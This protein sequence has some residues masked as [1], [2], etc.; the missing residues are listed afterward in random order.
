MKTWGCL[1]KQ[2]IILDFKLAQF[3]YANIK[4][5]LPTKD[6]RLC[7]WGLSKKKLGQILTIFLAHT[8]KEMAYFTQYECVA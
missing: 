3:V 1:K 8:G 7:Y 6:R 4:D 5:H 2:P